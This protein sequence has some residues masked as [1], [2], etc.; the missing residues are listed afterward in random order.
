MNRFA[1]TIVVSKEAVLSKI[2]FDYIVNMSTSWER[3][4]FVF[5]ETNINTPQELREYFSNILWEMKKYDISHSWE[6][7]MEIIWWECEEEIYECAT[8]EGEQVDFEEMKDRFEDFD[9]VVSI[10]E[11]ELSSKFWNRVI[12]VDFVY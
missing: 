5:G 4:V 6:D 2:E 12:K 11:A 7:K 8:F 3:V 1:W 9:G 10:R